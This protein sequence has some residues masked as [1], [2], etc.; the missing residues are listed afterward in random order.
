MKRSGAQYMVYGYA[1]WDEKSEYPMYRNMSLYLCDLK[2][3]EE[4]IYI[5]SDSVTKREEIYSEIVR[6]FPKA[7]VN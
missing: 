3:K 6:Y 7:I 5:H 4:L 2:T 1:L